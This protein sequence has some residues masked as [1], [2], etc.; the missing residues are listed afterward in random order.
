ML[1][2]ADLK[3][4]ARRRYRDALV[5]IV[6]DR[7]LFPLRVPLGSVPTDDLAALKE[8]NAALE[9]E[10]VAHL[11]CGVTV[12]WSV[13]KT[14]L[15]NEQRVPVQV[16]FHS[17]GDYGRY[18]KCL[19]EI[20]AFR[21]AV[22]H[23]RRELP[24]LLPWM[25]RHPLRAKDKISVWPD[26]VQVCRHFIAN[27]MPGCYTR[28]IR[29]PI[30]SKFIE[31][32]QATLRA[33]LDEVL[34]ADGRTEATDF[35]ARFGLKLDDMQIRLRWLGV[36]PAGNPVALP[37]CS[38]PLHI[39]AQ[40]NLAPC[41]VFVVENKTTFLTLPGMGDGWL[42]IWGNGNSVPA[43]GNLP[44]LRECPLFY[45]GDIDPAGFQILARLRNRLPQTRSALMD[46]ATLEAHRTWWGKAGNV[47]DT[48]P[49]TLTHEEKA[50]YLRVRAE[51]IQLEQERVLQSWVEARCSSLR[52][53]VSDGQ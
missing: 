10:S 53:Q 34:P 52:Q 49:D 50:L 20:H 33:L 39:L 48:Y 37:D 31:E 21:A 32:E 11:G 6:E 1:G 15:F 14:R 25:A 44:W 28:E 16:E 26:L 40:T 9:A 47:A 4:F 36:P 3:A 23:T 41:G 7:S 46:L 29:L 17:E 5:A 51:S 22:A 12:T 35:H 30:G 43:C 27:P 8:G 18:L 42:A 2:P 45:W 13:T 19:D 24:A 38:A